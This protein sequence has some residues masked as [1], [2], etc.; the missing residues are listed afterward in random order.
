MV[1]FPASLPSLPPS[2]RG[3]SS[4]SV[5]SPVSHKGPVLARQ[6]SLVFLTGEAPGCKEPDGATVH[7][8]GESLTRLKRLSAHLAT[9]RVARRGGHCVYTQPCLLMWTVQ[10]LPATVASSAGRKD[11]MMAVC[12]RSG[13]A[14]RGGLRSGA[15]PWEVLGQGLSH[16]GVLGQGLFRGRS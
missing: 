7:G 15:V 10:H 8:V 12:P 16:G 13:S 2:S 11:G 5:S 4:V 3:F 14:C 9:S 1:L 6:A